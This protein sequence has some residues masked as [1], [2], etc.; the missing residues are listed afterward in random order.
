MVADDLDETEVEAP[1]AKDV[2]ELAKAASE[3][4]D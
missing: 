4:C 2:N 3:D 1:E